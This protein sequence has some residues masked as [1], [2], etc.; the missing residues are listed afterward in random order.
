MEEKILKK[1]A[2]GLMVEPMT[3]EEKA[4]CINEIVRKG[5]KF[6]AS[7]VE[8]LN[9]QDLAYHVIQAWYDYVMDKYY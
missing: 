4:W 9:D 5:E 2:A 7:E 8:H 3:S 1:Y 6:S